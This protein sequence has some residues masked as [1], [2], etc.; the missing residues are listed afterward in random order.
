MSY[1]DYL[2][3]WRIL[4]VVGGVYK[5]LVCTSSH[6][7]ADRMGQLVTWS[8]LC[9]MTLGF[10]TGLVTSS[11][12][13][14]R[15]RRQSDSWWWNAPR[16]QPETGWGSSRINVGVVGQSRQLPVSSQHPIN[17]RCMEDMM[18]VTVQTDLYG[19]GKLVKASDLALGPRQCRPSSQS[20]TT[21]IFQQLLQDCGNTLQMSSDWL[22]YS[23]MLTYNPTP[24]RNSPIIRTNAAVVTIQCY[25]PRHGNVSSNA[26][27]PTWLPF[28]ST[29]SAEER[30]SF[31]LKLMTDDWS[32]PRTSTVFQ[33][34]DIFHIEASVDTRNHVPMKVFIDRCMA[35][36]SPDVTSS[37]SYDIIAQNGCLMDGKQDDASSAF[38]SPRLTPD[39]LQFT[40]DAFRFIG[41]DNSMIY[42]T[43]NLRAAA[44]NQVPDPLNKACSF[45]KPRNTWTDLE[46]LDDICSCCD[47][48]NCL[49]SGHTRGL[50]G[51]HRLDKRGA[52]SGT[53][54]QDQKLA[55]LGPL[56][57]VGADKSQTHTVTQE[58]VSVALWVL[59]A[60]ITLSLLVIV[61]FGIVVVQFKKPQPKVVKK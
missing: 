49:S 47:S 29:I 3:K 16:S 22:I 39:R 28:S 5:V 4:Q 14:T 20:T 27:K 7:S 8:V 44:Q 25:Y 13:L 53:S 15:T 46:G 26:I 11:D 24:S 9:L 23:T 36:L 58:S 51:W 37:P 38:R 60:V 42:I 30:L 50:F 32:G 45:N 57:V 34:G 6:Y 54:E 12:E 10:R 61:G 52:A 1:T 43:C 55:I 56:L 59:V 2:L 35:T 21:V 41:T 48:G 19:T 17:V 31:A 40:V 18:V 33:L